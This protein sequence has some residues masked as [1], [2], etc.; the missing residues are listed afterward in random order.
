[1]L[2]ELPRRSTEVVERLVLSSEGLEKVEMRKGQFLIL[3]MG[4][5]VHK[6]EGDYDQIAC[7]TRAKSAGENWIIIELLALCW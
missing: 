7:L 6:T 2:L 3:S 5:Q 1:M 4:V